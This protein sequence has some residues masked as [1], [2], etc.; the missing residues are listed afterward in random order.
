MGA[1]VYEIRLGAHTWIS[2][3]GNSRGVP[4][5]ELFYNRRRAL[6]ALDRSRLDPI[7]AWQAAGINL[8]AADSHWDIVTM[9]SID[10]L[11]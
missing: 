4:A 3:P 10:E 11:T 5:A 9:T 2:A 7:K 6:S 8:L 1:L